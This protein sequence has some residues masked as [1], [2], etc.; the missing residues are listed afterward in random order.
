MR[1][2]VFGNH[3]GGTDDGVFPHGDAAEEGRAGADGCAFFH[4]GRHA[5]PILFGLEPAIG[6][7]T[8]VRVVDERDVVADEHFVFEGDAFT[9]EGVA[10]DFTAVADFHPFLDFDKVPDFDVIA[11]LAAVEIDDA[12]DANA[13]AQFNIGGDLLMWIG[14]AQILD[15]RISILDL[16]GQGSAK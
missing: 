6:G 16:R 8:R 15:F 3:A 13:F 14:G 11:D 9:E 1:W 2:N 4:Q 5:F 12:I 10:G 7:G